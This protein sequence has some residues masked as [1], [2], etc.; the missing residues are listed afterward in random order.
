V[1]RNWDR[2]C[3]TR[4]GVNVVPDTSSQ[5]HAL[6]PC[7]KCEGA[8]L[9][10]VQGDGFTSYRCPQCGGAWFEGTTLDKALRKAPAPLLQLPPRPPDPDAK[11]KKGMCPACKTPMI[12]VNALTTPRVVMDVCKVCGGRWLDPGEFPLIRGK[13]FFAWLRRTFTS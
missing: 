11:D 10:A 6:K 7:P 12:K 13:G 1:V 2:S 9:E 5:L 3:D 4:P 8:L